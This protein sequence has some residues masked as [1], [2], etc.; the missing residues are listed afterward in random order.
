MRVALVEP[1][2]STEV[3]VEP[4]GPLTRSVTWRRARS[5]KLEVDP[6]TSTAV[7]PTSNPLTRVEMCRL[8]AESTDVLISVLESETR[9]HVL[10]AA[11]EIIGEHA[12]TEWERLIVSPLL[13]LLSHPSPF[14]REGAVY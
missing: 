8:A 14:V 7:E 1:G 2:T 6:A 5:T 12:P 9:T 11:A 3:V 4:A 13:R 10:S